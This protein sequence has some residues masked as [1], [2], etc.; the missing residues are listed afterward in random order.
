MMESN[1]QTVRRLIGRQ[2]TAVIYVRTDGGSVQFQAA[3]QKEGE[4]EGDRGIWVRT[5]GAPTALVDRLIKS[6]APV[7]AKIEDGRWEL[8][9]VSALLLRQKPLLG[10]ERV[11]LGWPGVID[12]K[13]L[14]QS[15]RERVAHPSPVTAAL[16]KGGKESFP[17][18]GLPL[19]VWDVSVHGACL[20]C[21]AN[22]GLRLNRGD[23]LELRLSIG[24][25]EYRVAARHC[26]TE[27][28][29]S[30]HQRFGVEFLAGAVPEAMSSQ[31]QNLVEQIRGERERKHI[32]KTM[33]KG[34]W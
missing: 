26:R 28:L 6:N 3:F 18:L 34:T 31:L 25:S 13:E 11:L 7:L 27:T 4:R 21:P 32:E 19:Q 22:F 23:Q 1:E 17:G 24:G 8:S 10:A 9:F 16:I 2:A 5:A 12:S 15:P 33:V 29:Q 30:G 20:I 14:R